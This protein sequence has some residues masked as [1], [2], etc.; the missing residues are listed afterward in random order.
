[1]RRSLVAAAL[2]CALALV[3]PGRAISI[4]LSPP[5]EDLP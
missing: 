2:G 3:E 5:I 4:A 1:M